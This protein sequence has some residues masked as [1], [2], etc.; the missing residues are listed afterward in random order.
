M[1]SNSGW[2]KTVPSGTSAISQ[3]DDAIRSLKSHMQEWW[4]D[5]HYATDGSTN[6]AGVHKTGSARAYSQ[7]AQPTAVL[8]KGQLWHDPDDDA[9]YIYDGSS[10]QQISANIT[11]AS[12]NSWSGFNDFAG[13]LETSDLSINGI[14]D[15]VTSYTT[16][17]DFSSV[18]AQGVD[19]VT[20]T[21]GAAGSIAAGDMVILANVQSSSALI[22]A[23]DTPAGGG[24][25]R[26][27]AHNPSSGAVDP[28][29]I[30]LTC[31]ILKS[32]LSF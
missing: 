31:I 21:D 23:A 26:F 8:P 30:T 2:D 5:E 28:S 13:G 29:A 15:G 17:I 3:G 10:W 14:F 1:A 11:L 9:F 18:A 4:E 24:S 7:S 12:N 20:A 19:L 27:R 25:I 22:F 32:G 6:S 16:L